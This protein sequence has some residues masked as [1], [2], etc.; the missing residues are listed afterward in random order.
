L[1]SDITDSLEIVQPFNDLLQDV[2]NHHLLAISF[3]PP[4]LPQRELPFF[5]RGLESF[6]ED[7]SF[8]TAFEV[9]A[10]PEVIVKGC[11]RFLP[12]IY[13][14]KASLRRAGLS[15]T[16]LC[17]T[18][19]SMTGLSKTRLSRTG[20]RRTGLRRT[21][22]SWT[23]LSWTGL[24]LRGRIKGGHDGLVNC[25]EDQTLKTGGGR[26]V[27]WK[28]AW[29]PQPQPQRLQPFLPPKAALCRH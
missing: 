13:W 26:E 14:L 24:S 3:E 15:H 2:P 1:S 5:L 10:G 9:K 25:W 16:G 17:K 18:G 27:I 29:M 23:G 4:T 22:L 19:L 12:Q 11:Q 8:G 20:L 7:I 6:L 28:T 21:G